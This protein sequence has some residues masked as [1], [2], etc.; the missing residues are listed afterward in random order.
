VQV[1]RVR[2]GLQACEALQENRD[3]LVIPEHQASVSLAL[4]GDLELQATLVYLVR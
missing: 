1:R 2:L 3:S 4:Q